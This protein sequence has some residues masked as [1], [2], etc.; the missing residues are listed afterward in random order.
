MTC[1]ILAH[2]VSEDKKVLA[3]KENLL[4]L[5]NGTTVFSSPVVKFS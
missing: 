2:W 4:V 3:E 5:D 1:L